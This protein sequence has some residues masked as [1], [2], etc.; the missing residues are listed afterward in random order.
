MSDRNQHFLGK[1]WQFPPSFNS[2]DGSVE[3]ACFEDDIRQSLRILLSTRPGERVMHPT[4]GCG[5]HSL[6]FELISETSVT[7]ITDLI[8]R[9]V[10][11]F[12]PRITLDLVSVNADNYYQGRIDII[13]DYTIRSTNTRSNM[14]YPFYF[15]EGTDLVV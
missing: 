7:E 3:I 12:E 13:L 14:V 6:I 2:S 5:L 15:S 4:F 11:F 1:G 8:R 10:L 9:A